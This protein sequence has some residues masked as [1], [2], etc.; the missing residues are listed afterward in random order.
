MPLA[1]LTAM[2]APAGA[3]L[4][5]QSGKIIVPELGTASKAGSPAGRK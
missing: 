5:P 2:K 3:F 4:C 1:R